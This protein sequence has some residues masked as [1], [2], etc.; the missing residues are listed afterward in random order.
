MIEE[1]EEEDGDAAGEDDEVFYQVPSNIRYSPA[2][3]QAIDGVRY[4]AKNLRETDADVKVC[5]SIQC[6]WQN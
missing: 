5:T 6:L 1:E 4:I 3:Q 2:M